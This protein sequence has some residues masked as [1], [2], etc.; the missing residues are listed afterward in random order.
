[1]R[2]NFR[3]LT[4]N[5]RANAMELPISTIKGCHYEVCFHVDCHEI[6]LHFQGSSENNRS[7]SEGFRAYLPKLES[8]MGYPMILES[9][10][11]VDRKRLWI[12][13]PIKSLTPDLLG[14]YSELTASLVI[15]TLSILQDIIA[16][17][18]FAKNW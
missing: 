10:E 18:D 3:G 8:S 5:Y 13:L 9:H 14:K 1:M 2:L 12:K 17:E 4:P 11:R 16:K 7:R 15:F 6:A